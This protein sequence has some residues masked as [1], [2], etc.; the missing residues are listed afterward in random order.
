MSISWHVSRNFMSD[1]AV[2]S[3]SLMVILRGRMWKIRHRLE[4]TNLGTA[5]FLSSRGRGSGL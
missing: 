1:R 3:S 2:I 5:A 4:S